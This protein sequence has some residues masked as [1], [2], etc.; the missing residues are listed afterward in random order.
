[1]TRASERTDLDLA[2]H[3]KENVL[4]FVEVTLHL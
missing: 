1:M 4:I 3:L 2:K